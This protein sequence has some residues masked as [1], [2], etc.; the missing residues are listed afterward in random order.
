MMACLALAAACTN[1]PT[2]AAS[3]FPSAPYSTNITRLLESTDDPVST[4][5]AAVYQISGTDT[6]RCHGPDDIDRARITLFQAEVSL[7]CTP[8][9]LRAPTKAHTLDA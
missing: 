2:Y 9:P 4:F 1:V 5:N 6:F 8:P 3:P 7:A